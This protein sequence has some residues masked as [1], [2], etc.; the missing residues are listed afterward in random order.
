M[1]ILHLVVL[2]MFSITGF[3][4]AGGIEP[5]S[6]SVIQ[7]QGSS[8]MLEFAISDYGSEIM[9]IQG[10]DC[11]RIFLPD[12]ATFLEPGL[13]ELPTVCRNI[14]IPDDALMDYRI[15]EIEEETKSTSTIIPSKGNLSRKIDPN[16]IPYTFDKFYNTDTWWPDKTIELSQPFMLR[17]YRGLN[18]RFNP[19]QYNPARQELKIVRRLVLEIYEIGKGGANVVCRPKTSATREFAGIYEKTFLNFGPTRYDSLSEIAGRMLIITA[20]AYLANIEPF[21]TWKRRKGI[22]TK[23]VPV[24]QIIGGNTQTAIKNLIQTEYDAGGLVWVLLVGDGN[25]VVPALGTVGAAY[26]AAADPVYAYTA[27]SDLYPDI[28][29][30]RFSSRG[31]ALNIDKQVSRSIGYE[32]EPEAGADWYHIGLGV[33]SDLDGGTPYADSTRMN[34]LND[35]LL[36]YTYTEVNKSYDPWA[37]PPP[38][39]IGTYLEAGTSIVNYIGHGWTGG[40]GNGGGF[41]SSNFTNLNNPWMLPLV[42]SVACDVGNF[43]GSSDCFCEVSVTAGDTAQPD[44]FLVHW[45]SSISQSWVP[46]CY[47]QEGAVN[48]LT[49]DEYNTAGGMLFGGADYMIGIYG[50]GAAGVEMAQTWHIFGDGSVQLRTDTPLN[51]MVGHADSINRDQTTFEVVVVGVENAL[52]GLYA[53]TMLLGSGYTDASGNAII[54]LDH[55]PGSNEIMYITVTAYNRVPYFGSVAITGIEETSNNDVH[56]WSVGSLFLSPNP[57]HNVLNIKFQIPEAVTGNQEQVASIMIYDITG[58]TIREFANLTNNQ[59]PFNQITW[60]GCDNLGN[61]VSPGVYFVELTEA[62]YIAVKKIIKVR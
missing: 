26:N 52:V 18:I 25:E 22:D 11:A 39:L 42:I 33:A 3:V 29:V 44:G 4:F 23:V 14:I 45:G 62:N 56:A 9:N 6:I 50:G 19:F 46:P 32:K 2:S 10:V 47:G 5:T 53:D 54:N 24:S 21:K 51:M 20:D 38:G 17:D 34:W 59:S 13:P 37:P 27:G 12:A 43:N 60:D 57:F 36:D 8:I 16:L 61:R 48:L 49:H 15:I 1:K 41:S 35:S 7:D 40:W 31:A 55:T 28:I 30:S 58:R